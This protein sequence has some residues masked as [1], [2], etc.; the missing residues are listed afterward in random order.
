MNFV[1]MHGLGNDFIL[2]DEF[3]AQTGLD[4]AEAARKLCDRRRGIG[5]DG[6]LLL[7]PAQDA[8]AR[9]RVFNADGS[10]AEMCGNGVRCLAKYV[11]DAGYVTSEAF[12]IQTEAGIKNVWL[13]ADGGSGREIRVNMG[14][15][16]LRPDWIP[17]LARQETA[18]QE[19]IEMDGHSFIF[20]AVS[21]GNPH[22]V[23]F[24]PAIEEI[25]LTEVGPALERHPLFP[26]RTNVE[27][28]QVVNRRE[29]ILR[30]WERGAGATQA[31]GTGACAAV[32]AGVLEGRL[33]RE[34]LVLL[35]GGALRVNWQDSGPL[36]MSGP[37]A[38]AFR[39]E[40]L[41]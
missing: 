3:K 24:T 38:Y 36:L 37:A 27:F 22:C 19:K 35:P 17:A 2:A 26:A 32:V 39:G 1:K 21:I 33:E 4:Y 31:C 9:M 20:T 40:T 25:R 18:V 23:I 13:S 7:L 14:I 29:I 11:Y 12:T 30:V 5:G 8:E 10:E 34:A 6:L 28:A 15:P 16:L 41:Q